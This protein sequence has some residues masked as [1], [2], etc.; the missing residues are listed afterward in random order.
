[1]EP[2]TTSRA[3]RIASTMHRPRIVW[4]PLTHASHVASTD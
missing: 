4:F 2:V 1:L 3:P